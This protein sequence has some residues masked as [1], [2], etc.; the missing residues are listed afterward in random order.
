MQEQWKQGKPVLLN[1][2]SN[3]LNS[4]LWH[5]E[6]LSCDFG[7]QINDIIDIT[8]N[9]VLTN[10]PMSTFWEG[11]ENFEKRLCN[12]QGNPMFLKLKDWPLSQNPVTETLPDRFQD[13]MNCL[14][15]KEYTHCSGQFNMVSHLPDCFVK[16][17]LGLKI[18]AAYGNIGA[19]LEKI[20][21]TNLHTDI[22][23]A[24][25]VMV[26]V[27]STKLSKENDDYNWHTR[28]VYK[29]IREAG[30]DD[31]TMQKINIFGWMPGAL[32]HIYQASDVAAIN[33]F[34][35]KVAAEQGI[36]LEDCSNPIHNQ[37]YYLDNS[38]RDRLLR[39]YGVK[40]YPVV[41]FNGDVVFIPAG[42]PY[43]VQYYIRFP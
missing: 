43:Q 34:L 38:L 25:H 29:E 6:S 4:K 37:L 12:E 7:D 15:L 31:F 19:Q 18:D 16:S 42:A 22:L 40:G 9:T 14:P 11:F 8:T 28:A 41:Q 23:D 24:V 20:G 26:Y 3:N 39:E 17:D 36:L 2:G 27:S 5:P 30:C 13:F 33:I 21:T 35:V 1:N 10:N 32:W